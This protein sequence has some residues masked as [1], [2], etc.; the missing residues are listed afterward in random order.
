M[1]LRSVAVM[2]AALAGLV[3]A[4]DPVRIAFYVGGGTSE[5]LYNFDLT[6]KEAAVSAFGAEG[7]RVVN[8]TEAGV[9]GL[10]R[11]DYD[12]VVFPGGSGGGQARA[13]N[14]TGLAAVR[15]FVEAGGGYIGT[16]GGAFLAIQH[17]LLYGSPAPKTQ[18]PWNRGHGAVQVEFSATGRQT[19]GL[20]EKYEGNVTIIYWQGPIVKPEDFPEYVQVFA[21]YRTEIHSLHTNETTGEMINTPAVTSRD[22]AGGRVVLNSPHPEIPLEDGTRRPEIYAG[23]LSYIRQKQLGA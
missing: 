23:E 6:L 19:L 8:V 21:T 13:I 1:R 7:F 9:Q 2:L 15:S 22:G 16:C 17:L 20:G 18:E 4:S 5:N 3:V 14:T 11:S 10:R 12:I